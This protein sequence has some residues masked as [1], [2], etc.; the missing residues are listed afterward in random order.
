LFILINLSVDIAYALLDPR[1][2][3]RRS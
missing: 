1:L 2:R 3:H